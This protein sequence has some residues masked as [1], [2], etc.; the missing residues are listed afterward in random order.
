MPPDVATLSLH[1]QLKEATADVHQALHVDPLLRR[2][3]MPDCS[4][5][6]YQTI[7]QI[8]YRFYCTAEFSLETEIRFAHE[9]PVLLWLQED[10]RYLGCALDSQIHHDYIKPYSDIASYLGYLYVKQGSTLGGQAIS[11]A[12]QKNLHLSPTE[13]LRFF[14]GYGASTREIWLE[15][16]HFLEERE[17]E[18]DGASVVKSAVYHFYRLKRL[19]AESHHTS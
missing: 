10:L 18:I 2:L 5:D 1:Q 16:L 4:L 19:F 8:F 9:A 13:G 17:A 3:L 12:L 11:R 7:L 15:F 6:E 14:S